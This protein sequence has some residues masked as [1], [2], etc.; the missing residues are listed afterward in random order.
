MLG[1]RFDYQVDMRQQTRAGTIRVPGTP[2]VPDYSTLDFISTPGAQVTLRTPDMRL[3]LRYSPQIVVR[4]PTVQL[5]GPMVLHRANLTFQLG[6][7]SDWLFSSAASLTIG[8]LDLANASALVQEFNGVLGPGSGAQVAKYFGLNGFVKLQ[9]QVGRAWTFSTQESAGFL[10][11]PPGSNAGYF[12]GSPGLDFESNVA[13]KRQLTATSKNEIDYKISSRQTLQFTTALSLVSFPA[14]ATYLG[15]S[16][17]LGW[18]AQISKMTRLTAKGGF[19]KYWANPHPGIYLVPRY[20]GIAE[21]A[22]DRSFADIGLPRLHGRLAVGVVPYYDLVLGKVVPRGSAT[23]E[24]AY[25]ISR[26]L[27]ISTGFRWYTANYYDGKNWV[28]VAPGR[29]RNIAMT[30]V[31]VKYKYSSFLD[32]EAGTIGSVR[33]FVPT[34]TSP[35]LMQEEGYVFL[36]VT[37]TWQGSE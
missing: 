3:M 37:G 2:V 30:D 36:G 21:L 10:D 6:R 24:A 22:A 28:R 29:V 5:T 17:T 15:I 26:K 9:K 7:E 16:P 34:H 4:W 27:Q 14:T 11:T 32:V 18:Q 8:Q 12:T 13:L 20:L 33:W 35:Y 25:E 31:R 23:A 1:M 19:L